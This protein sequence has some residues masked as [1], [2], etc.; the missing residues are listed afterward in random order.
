MYATHI[1]WFHFV[2]GYCHFAEAMRS[3]DSLSLIGHLFNRSLCLYI[4]IAM[5]C[6]SIHEVEV[7]SFMSARLHMRAH[8]M[9]MGKT[10]NTFFINSVDYD[11]QVQSMREEEKI[12]HDDL[13]NDQTNLRTSVHHDCMIIKPINET[14]SSHTNSSVTG[15]RKKN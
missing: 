10:P 6:L 15:D 7:C 4:G 9:R 3:Y 8:A 14:H 11:I 5:L 2:V 1:V 12:A 13:K